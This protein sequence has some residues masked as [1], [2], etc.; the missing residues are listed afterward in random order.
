MADLFGLMRVELSGEGLDVELVVKIAEGGVMVGISE[1][2]LKR[3]EE[4]HRY[5]DRLVREERVVYGVTT[6]FGYLSSQ[7]VSRG[8][9]L[10][11]QENLVRSHSAGVGESLSSQ[12]VRAAM[13][14][15]LNA[16]LKGH[17][18]VS[19][20][21]VTLM[22]EML[23]RDI[24]PLV[25]EHGSLGASGDLAPL[26]HIALCLMGEGLVR[27]RGDVKPASRAFEEEGL[28]PV[29]LGAKEGLA[30]I[31]G[32]QMTTAGACF[33]VV[34]AKRLL[35]AF[36]L[37]AAL[38]LQALGCRLDFLDERIHT[39]RG[40]RGQLDSAASLRA[41]L[42]GST[43]TGASG[44]VQEPYSIRCIPQVHGAAREALGFAERIVSTE[45]NAATDNPLLFPADDAVLSGGNFHAQPVAMVLDLLAIA[46]L[47]VGNL[48]ERR[49]ERLL[50]PAHSG[51][52]PFLSRKSGLNSG[53]MV[54]Q[55]TAASILGEGRVLAHPASVDTASV[56]AGQE[57]HASMGFAAAKKLLRVLEGLW[58]VAAVEA[59]CAVEAV[60]LV[61]GRD[62]LSPVSRRVYDEVR[63]VVP[64][65][66]D[67]A[68]VGP[69]IEAVKAVL[70]KLTAS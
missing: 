70:K 30:L 62:G 35:E 16:L 1:E 58:Y 4:A 37:A 29:R 10:K 26:A 23:N 24:V 20:E 33:G 44:R 17:S 45:I 68:V 28:R 36:E 54:A 47:P 53:Y 42:A 55:Y 61:G 67:D 38:T 2:A 18:G 3:V 32:T 65:L 64:P 34:E 51:L 9:V 66:E 43:L 48:S 13:V 5:V 21:T 57:D 40:L 49:V 63:S 15:R 27:H 39:A 41:K 22:A 60:D 8:D 7:R 11:L 50:N 12:L 25:P 19:S 52:P 46:M 31:N 56:S 14:L 69:R 59:L 6:G